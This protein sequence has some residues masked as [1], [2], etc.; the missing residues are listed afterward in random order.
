MSRHLKI[1]L[2]VAGVLW[3]ASL[4]GWAQESQGTSAAKAAFGQGEALREKAD[5]AKAVAAY[6]KAIELDPDF[7]EAHS[8]FIFASKMSVREAADPAKSKALLE[9]QT[10]QLKTLYESWA[11]KDPKRASYQWALG[12]LNMY[13]DYA[14]VV[15]HAQKAVELD[16]QFARAWQTL[17]LVAEVQG[18]NAKQLAYLKKAAD[19]APENPAYAFYYA[20]ALKTVDPVAY[21]KASLQVVERFPQHE[22]GAQSLYWLAFYE[23]ALVK[24]L[25]LLERLKTQF[26]VTK[27]NWSASG[28]SMLFDA[29][30]K[31][32]PAKA[33]ALAEELVKAFPS[34]SQNKTWQGLLDFQKNLLQARTLVNS[35]K[36]AEAVALLDATAAPRYTD[37]SELFLLKA[38]AAEGAGQPQKAYDELLRQ[39]VKEP[40]AGLRAGVNKLGAKLNK[41]NAQVEAD[42]WQALD[43]QAKPATDFK[44]KR[45]GADQELSLADYRGKVV[46]LNFWY[47]FCGPCR[48]ENPGLQRVLKKIGPD[49]FVILAVNVYP[50]EDEF[51]LPY[52]QGNAFDFIPLRGSEELAEKQW[53]ARGYPTNFLIDPQGR[54]VYRLGPMRGEASERTFEMQIEMLLARQAQPGK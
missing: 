48:G 35:Q 13:K 10:Q 25:A 27:F 20:N 9:E 19:V 38:A 12:D 4:T 11:Q 41:T 52:L 2:G 46:L 40:T 42:L 28:M 36:F 39:M 43:A 7:A 6:R 51:V 54:T 24:K 1:G 16:P 26:P 21:E 31:A 53:G 18:D 32:A 34:G 17:A 49:K 33:L 22:R 15:A 47:P 5:F 37:A 3:L 45:Y 30:A 14:K 44:L 23:N 29:Y 8:Q 50:A